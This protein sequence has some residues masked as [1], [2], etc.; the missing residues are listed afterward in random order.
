MRDKG[1]GTKMILSLTRLLPDKHRANFRHPLRAI[2]IFIDELGI[3]FNRK[4]LGSYSQH[5]E[6]IIIHRLLKN[7]KNGLYVDVGANDPTVISNTRYFYERGWR[8]INIEP[9]P[10]LF[11]KIQENRPEDINLNLGIASDEGELTYYQI[12]ETNGTAGSTFDK[13][14]AE[15]RIKQGYEISEEIKMPV[16]PLHYLFEVHLGNREI[17]FMSIDTE[18]FDLEV[19]KSNNWSMYR[20]KIVVVETVNNKQEIVE[21][22]LGQNYLQVHEN[23]ANTFFKDNT[24]C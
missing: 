24:S 9:H 6:D 3:T 1:I 7:K 21:F 13:S 15:E 5:S 12:N 16:K 4:L 2:K 19:I 17:D 10:H 8:G 14:V 23:Q 22:M 18:G 20:P 11:K